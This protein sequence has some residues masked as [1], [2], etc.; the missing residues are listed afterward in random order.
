MEAD[1]TALGRCVVVRG[2]A[3]AHVCIFLLAPLARDVVYSQ[4]KAASPGYVRLL[5]DASV[6]HASGSEGCRSLG[7][8]RTEIDHVRHGINHL[9]RPFGLMFYP[10]ETLSPVDIPWR[11]K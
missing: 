8:G 2:A 6:R 11:G 1:I 7:G 3:A 10:I 9:T 5:L 4:E